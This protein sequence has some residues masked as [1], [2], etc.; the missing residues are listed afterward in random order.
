MSDLGVVFAAGTGKFGEQALWL[1]RSLEQTNPDHTRYVFFPESENVSKQKELQ[2]MCTVVKGEKTIPE[3][4]IS[5]KIDAL[6]AAEEVANEESL[7]LLDTDTLVL[8]PLR[9]HN[10]DAEM[11]L[12]PV[13]IGRQYWGRKNQSYNEW[14]RIAKSL[15]MP[16]P[17]WSFK[18]TFDHISIP[19]YWNAGFVLVPNDGFG[20]RWLRA[21]ENIYPDLSYNWHADQVTLGLLSQSYNVRELTNCYNYPLHLRLRLPADT[22]VVHYHGIE[23]LR[24]ARHQTELFKT[25]GLSEHIAETEYSYLNGMWRYFKRKFFPLNEEHTLE[26]IANRLS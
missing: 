20:K 17:S 16:V 15:D 4:P 10:G 9:L 22:A 7:L 11:F 23:N 18:S 12:K 2:D 5:T 21:V 14:A 19:P 8:R 26:R 25:I 24:K 13:D 3:Y 6:V 1:A